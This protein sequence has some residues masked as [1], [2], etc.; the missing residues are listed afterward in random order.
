MACALDLP[1]AERTLTRAAGLVVL[2]LIAHSFVDYPL[3]TNAML[4][5]FAFACALLVDPHRGRFPDHQG[6]SQISPAQAQRR[7]Q[8][9]GHRS[10]WIGTQTPFTVEG[11]LTSAVQPSAT[12]GNVRIAGDG[13]MT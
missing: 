3:R 8:K 11:T 9:Q 5:V 1:Q 6:R 13:E 2:L 7:E 10:S 4:G 12:D